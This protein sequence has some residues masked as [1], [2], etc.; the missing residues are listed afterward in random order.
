MFASCV[1][2][3]YKPYYIENNSI[4]KLENSH[5]FHN[6]NTIKLNKDGDKRVLSLFLE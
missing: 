6:M 1:D 2:L 3:L 5:D 4:V